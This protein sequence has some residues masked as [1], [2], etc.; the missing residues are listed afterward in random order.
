MLLTVF[1]MMS[2]VNDAQVLK[3]FWLISSNPSGNSMETNE[4]HPQNAK[5]WILRTVDGMVSEVND[6]QSANVNSPISSRP[7]GNTMETKE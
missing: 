4:E 6:V 7:C 5:S 2:E 3:D 1:G